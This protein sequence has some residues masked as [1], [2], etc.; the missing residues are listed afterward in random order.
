MEILTQTKWL[1]NINEPVLSN[2]IR[3]FN[4]TQEPIIDQVLKTIKETIFN[5]DGE[6]IDP[7]EVITGAINFA[8]TLK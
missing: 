3:I 7:P 4:N 1:S 2:K 5:G 8:V 6:P